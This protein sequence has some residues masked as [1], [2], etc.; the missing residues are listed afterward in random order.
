MDLIKAGVTAVG[1]LLYLLCEP[2]PSGIETSPAAATV[3]LFLRAATETT[4]D[5]IMLCS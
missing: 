3:E 5:K 1:V 2:F 4:L